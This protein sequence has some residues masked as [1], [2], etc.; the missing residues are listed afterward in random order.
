[1]NALVGVRA[2][3]SG[4]LSADPA[5]RRAALLDVQSL[6]RAR[7]V[8]HAKAVAAKTGNE[9]EIAAGT[10]VTAPIAASFEVKPK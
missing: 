9:V 10:V 2:N 3:A 6:A 5:K 8:G 7:L 1:M 4:L